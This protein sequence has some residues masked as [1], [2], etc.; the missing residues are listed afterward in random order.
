MA[1]I[2]GLICEKED[3]GHCYFVVSYP[4]SPGTALQDSFYQ[5]VIAPREPF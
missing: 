2:I 1:K 5:K 3:W 4:L